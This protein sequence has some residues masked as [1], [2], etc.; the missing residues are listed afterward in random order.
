MQLSMRTYTARG[1]LFE[2]KLVLHLDALNHA[3]E[4]FRGKVV[5]LDKWRRQ[6]LYHGEEPPEQILSCD[7]LKA[8][9]YRLFLDSRIFQ[10]G[11]DVDDFHVAHL[12]HKLAKSRRKVGPERAGHPKRV[13][14]RDDRDK[15][16]VLVDDVVP[17]YRMD[18]IGGHLSRVPG[19]E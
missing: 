14:P 18:N 13:I 10:N 1:G 3:V 4:L 11:F 15:D 2:R 5:K 9:E 7:L 6:S 12:D 16:I 19:E 17:E 8:V